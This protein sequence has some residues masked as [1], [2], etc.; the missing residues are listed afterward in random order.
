MTTAASFGGI[1]APAVLSAPRFV[2]MCE[3]WAAGLG[4]SKLGSLQSEVEF[5]E[6][7]YNSRLGNTHTK[8]FGRAKPPSITLERALD[9]LG[10]AQLYGWHLLA[11]VN[12]PLAKLPASFD[13][14]TKSGEPVLACLLE[15]AWCQKLEIDQTQADAS[16]VSMMRV[17]I[18]CDSILLL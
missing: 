9:S 6:Y 14:L 16:A 8:Q 3:G 12:N 13:I 7:S 4:F 18:V 1:P 2:I 17:T 5:Q 10:F 15:N 11:R